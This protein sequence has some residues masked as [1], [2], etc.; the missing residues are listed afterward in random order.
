MSAV[1]WGLAAGGA[2]LAALA[3]AADGAL[4]AEPPLPSVTAERS[5]LAPPAPVVPRPVLAREN[6]HRALALVRVLGH[7]TAGSGLAAALDL[8]GRP[9]ATAVALLI[10]LGLTVV[11]AAE[12]TARVIGDA[13]GEQAEERLTWFSHGVERL[14]AP[15]VRFGSW[16]DEA[17]AEVISDAEATIERREEAAAPLPMPNSP[18]WTPPVCVACA[19]TS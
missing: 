14:L 13:F 10:G 18:P 7:L 2:V 5:T 4:L 15:V 1:A 8:A 11:L 3:A 9:T 12:T 16:I 6:T 17:F 19:S